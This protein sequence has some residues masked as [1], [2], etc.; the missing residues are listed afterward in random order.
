MFKA[1]PTEYYYLTLFDRRYNTKIDVDN[2]DFPISILGG[3]YVCKKRGRHALVICPPAT[4]KR[5]T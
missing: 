4:Y 2:L 1:K 5:S 3:T